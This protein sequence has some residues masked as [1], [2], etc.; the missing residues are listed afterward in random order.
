VVLKM[1]EMEKNSQ[2]VV[3][4][5]TSGSWKTPHICIFPHAGRPIVYR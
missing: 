1:G 2:G 5:L 3:G 4:E